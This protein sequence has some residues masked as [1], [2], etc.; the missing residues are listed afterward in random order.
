[1]KTLAALALSAVLMT[2]ASAQI[3]TTTKGPKSDAT[4]LKIHKLDLVLKILPL[5]LKKEQY[6]DL[7]LAVAKARQKERELL[8]K[9][10]ETLEQLDSKL[11][12]SLD[13]ALT[14]GAYPSPE[15]VTEVSNKTRDSGLRRSFLMAQLTE[16]IY[17]DLT[18]SLNA[19]QIKV[20]AGS[21][22]DRYIDPSAKKGDLKDDLKVRFFITNVIL[23]PYSFDILGSLETAA[24]ADTTKKG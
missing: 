8:E 18:Q 11:T 16:S 13:A 20:M 23:D 10:D 15:L 5:A 14:K 6:K 4:N 9:E 7:L 2:S 19:G 12:D 21:F 22:D 24:T 1:M 17:K 3:I